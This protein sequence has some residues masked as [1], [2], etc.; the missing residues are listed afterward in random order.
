MAVILDQG[1][2]DKSNEKRKI[3]KNQLRKDTGVLPMNSDIQA[4]DQKKNPLN[5]LLMPSNCFEV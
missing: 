2:N 5:L 3:K 4:M 1:K